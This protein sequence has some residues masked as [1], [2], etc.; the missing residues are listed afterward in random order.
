[1][2]VVRW[3]GAEFLCDG[4]CGA[5]GSLSEA[6]GIDLRALRSRPPV[7]QMTIL[8][9]TLAVAALAIVGGATGHA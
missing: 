7:A 3:V 2:L 8:I 9:L 5:S 6:E 1:V 4:G